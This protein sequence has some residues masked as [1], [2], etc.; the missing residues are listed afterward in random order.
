L[1]LAMER[2]RLWALG[3]HIA[4][5]GSASAANPADVLVAIGAARYSVPVQYV[6][7]TV[8]VQETARFTPRVPSIW[9]CGWPWSGCRSKPLESFEFTC[10]ASIDVKV[11][12]ELPQVSPFRRDTCEGYDILGK[13]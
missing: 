3:R 8:T 4:T 6:G 13:R 1:E 9:P 11:V 2:S 12:R 7:R 10:Q 5:S